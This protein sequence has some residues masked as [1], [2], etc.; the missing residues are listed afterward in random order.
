MKKL[1]QQLALAGLCLSGLVG[2]STHLP[3]EENEG[4]SIGV[5]EEGAFQSIENDW[6]AENSFGI[7]VNQ[8]F[9]KMNRLNDQLNLDESHLIADKSYGEAYAKMGL[10][11]GNVFIHLSGIEATQTSNPIDI[12]M[13]VGMSLVYDRTNS[14]A[15]AYAQAFMDTFHQIS[16]Q[17]LLTSEDDEIKGSF[18]TW[19][20]DFALV[21]H[22]TFE[23]FDDQ[24][25]SLLTQAGITETNAIFISFGRQ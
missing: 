11:N 9:E 14:E 7:T 25:V 4:I 18:E 20:T 15:M 8:L 23:S 16:I 17:N 13:F 6:V 22:D 1:C 21:N 2:C 24:T 10:L 19:T 12:G 3:N 5:D